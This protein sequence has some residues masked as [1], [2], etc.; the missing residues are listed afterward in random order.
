M[1]SVLF[2]TLIEA[3]DNKK[4][5]FSHITFLWYT[6]FCYVNAYLSL[7][8]DDNFRECYDGCILMISSQITTSLKHIDVFLFYQINEGIRSDINSSILIPF[9]PMNQVCEDRLLTRSN[10]LKA[11][12]NKFLFATAIHNCHKGDAHSV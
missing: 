10:I 7:N 4:Y 6:S 11:W 5:I 8:C 2:R 9:I 3:C 12:W 1:E